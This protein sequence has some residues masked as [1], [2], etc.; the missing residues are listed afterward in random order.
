MM[1]IMR[2]SP[3][4]GRVRLQRPVTYS[5]VLGKRPIHRGITCTLTES[6]RRPCSMRICCG[7]LADLHR[8]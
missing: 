5:L 8:A 6:E 4:T 2:L 1:T 3:V 7:S